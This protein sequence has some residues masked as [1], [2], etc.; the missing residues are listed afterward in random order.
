MK[1]ISIIILSVLL[2]ASIILGLIVYRE[3]RAELMS[4]NTDISDLHGQ[5][6]EKQTT[7][8]SLDQE[9]K[10]ALLGKKFLLQKHFQNYCV[11]DFSRVES[12]M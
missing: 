8:T 2:T 11:Q 5:L 1:N 10:K 6:K 4:K 12:G 3:N 9:K 7:V